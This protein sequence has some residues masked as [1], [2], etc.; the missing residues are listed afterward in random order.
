VDNVLYHIH[1]Y[2][3]IRDS[4]HFAARLASSSLWDDN[5]SASTIISLP[6]VSASEFDAF[7]SVVY[8]LDFDETDISSAVDWTSVLRLATRWGFTSIVKRAVR[9]LDSLAG[10]VDKLVLGRAYAVDHWVS[11]ALVS[12]CQRQQPLTFDEARR[13]DIADVVLVHNV[14]E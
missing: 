14:R 1:R 5:H 13:M 7:L 8:P 2:F 6:D 10:P 4:T 9:Q 11:P 12:L 3:L